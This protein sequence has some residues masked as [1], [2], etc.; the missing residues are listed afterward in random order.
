MTDASRLPLYLMIGIS[1]VLH[2]LFLTGL[3]NLPWFTGPPDIFRL[4]RYVV[5]FPKPEP[6][7]VPTL[8]Q[9][10]VA[11][12]IPVEP[13]P[14]EPV[15]DLQ[16]PKPIERVET[17]PEPVVKRQ[18][19]AATPVKPVIPEP[20][21]Q[22]K[23][24]TVS[25]REPVVEPPPAPTATRTTASQATRRVAAAVPQTA[26]PV[27]TRAVAAPQPRQPVS[28][29]TLQAQAEQEQLLAE[30]EQ[31]ALERYRALIWERVQEHRRYLREVTERGGE[32]GRVVLQF[33][34]LSD[35]QVVSPE[36]TEAV[37]HRTFRRAALRVLKRIGQLPPLPP[38]IRR[39]QILIELPISFEFQL[40]ER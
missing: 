9:V 1:V 10:A 26:A 21:E 33:T 16:T 36:V 20:L 25:K 32:N 5:Q 3:P 2:G 39:Q 22:K 11:E 27:L 23:P 18:V 19:V 6:M 8:T 28:T 30:Q 24:R 15:A 35:G 13:A 38:N 4:T 37:G 29:A 7:Q 14:I 34:V 12:P 31:S 17:R 40:E